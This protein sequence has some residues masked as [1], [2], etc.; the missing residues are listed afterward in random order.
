MN[1]DKKTIKIFRWDSEEI[2]DANNVLIGYIE[3][4]I[5]TN[6]DPDTY[7]ELM[8]DTYDVILWG[9]KSQ[10]ERLYGDTGPDY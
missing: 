5:G 8:L 6:G 4:Q 7:R 10:R 2:R 3:R 1:P 9:D